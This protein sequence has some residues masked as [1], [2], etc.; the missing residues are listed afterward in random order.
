VKGSSIENVHDEVQRR[1]ALRRH[2]THTQQSGSSTGS[3][4]SQYRKSETGESRENCFKFSKTCE[5]H[6]VTD[7]KS[8]KNISVG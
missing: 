6:Y 3:L 2:K 4:E 8:P 5:R 7:S 1:G